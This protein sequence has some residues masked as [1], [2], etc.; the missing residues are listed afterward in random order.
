MKKLHRL[1]FILLLLTS[2]LLW[3]ACNKENQ[4]SIIPS[5][6]NITFEAYQNWENPEAKTIT[7]VNGEMGSLENLQASS[8]ETWLNVSIERNAEGL[9]Q[10]KVQPLVDGLDVDLHTAIITLSAQNTNGEDATIVVDFEI[11]EA[12]GTLDLKVLYSGSYRRDVYVFRLIRT[13]ILVLNSQTFPQC[14]GLYHEEES[15]EISEELAAGE[16]EL[17]LGSCADCSGTPRI[18]HFS[19]IPDQ[20]TSVTIN[21]HCQ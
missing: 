11:V 7:I 8:S 20:I 4:A 14:A 17:E 15:E 9:Y 1:Q 2:I 13:D 3:S 6:T 19:I 10:L 12:T 5:E 18:S 16:Y 21:V